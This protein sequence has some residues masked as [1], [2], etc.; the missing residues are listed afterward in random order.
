[1]T[2]LAMMRGDPKEVPV[3]LQLMCE[4]AADTVESGQSN[5]SYIVYC[6]VESRT[7]TRTLTARWKVVAA[8]QEPRR[9]LRAGLVPP[10][11]GG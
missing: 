2:R 10:S 6:R 3:V 1:M 4:Y 7:G 8:V 11:G 5:R 9:G